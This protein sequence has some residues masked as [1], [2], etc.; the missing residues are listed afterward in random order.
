MTS[1]DQPAEPVTPLIFAS[2]RKPRTWW[3]FF[4]RILL[5]YVGIPYL[6]LF[7]LMAVKQRALIYQAR[8][9]DRLSV[10]LMTGM[11]APA[12]D[13]E[14]QT[15]DG[16]TLH[17]WWFHGRSPDVASQK[18]L[19]I[20]FPGN[21]GCRENRIGDCRDF[22]MLGCD[23][24]LFDY[25]G[26][27]DNPGSPTEEWLG[28]DARRVWQLATEQRHVPADRIIL[29]GE[30]LGGAMA[31]RLAAEKSAEGTP[32]AALVLNSVFASL[33]ETA[34]WHYP[35]FPVR[36]V[37]LDQHPSVKRIPRVTCPI[38]QFHGTAD[39]VVP[40]Q[41]GRRLFDAAP[42]QSQRGIEKE[43]VSIP[44]G[45]HNYISMSHMHEALRGL[46]AKL[47]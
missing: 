12:E 31:T 9:T 18:Y 46:F 19:V 43:F 15:D 1:N 44:D 20:Y 24:V 7:G 32:P 38:M 33:G 45:E 13:V 39:T 47:E 21:A 22:T 25:R 16:L 10:E 3:W 30:S 14:I 34:G 5:I 23:V 42:A 28:A 29:F 36:A 2:T 6:F 11:E 17:G 35:V 27:G 8:K 41:H 26:Y 37:L 4:L 40:W